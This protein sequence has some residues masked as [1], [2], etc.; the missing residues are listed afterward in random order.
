MY[1]QRK[2]QAIMG[3]AILLNLSMGLLSGRAVAAADLYGEQNSEPSAAA[4]TVDVLAVRPLGIAAT[5]LGTGLF[6]VSLPF[7][8][9]G[10]NVDEVAENLVVEPA[11][12]TFTRPLGE[13]DA[14]H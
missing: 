5:L 8:A 12:F 10:G 13:Y 14:Y 7:S 6:I 2:K 3:L 9:L 1:K 4:M 11:R